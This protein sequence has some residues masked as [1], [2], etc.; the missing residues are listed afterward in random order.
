MWQPC[1]WYERRLEVH[2]DGLAYEN[3]AIE[4]MLIEKAITAKKSNLTQKKSYSI[5]FVFLLNNY[6]HLLRT[7]MAI[8]SNSIS[9][10]CQLIRQF[11]D[12]N[13]LFEYLFVYE[14]VCFWCHD[15][16]NAMNAFANKHGEEDKLK[17]TIGVLCDAITKLAATAISNIVPNV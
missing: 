9:L 14:L 17:I 6:F 16:P 3:G 15:L 11:C 8:M 12:D 13:S 1:F 5:E 10:F 4:F 2:Q 7:F